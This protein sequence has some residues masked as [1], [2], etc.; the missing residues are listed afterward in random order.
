ME[1]N[2]RFKIDWAGLII[3]RKFTAL[4][5]FTL[6]LRAISKYKSLGGLNWLIF[7]LE[8][9]LNE[10]VFLRYEFGGLILGE[11]YLRNLTVTVF[12]PMFQKENFEKIRVVKRTA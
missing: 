4:L 6:D 11:A 9:R 7:N 10:G 3:G 5:C 2:L 8:G 12:G 1:G